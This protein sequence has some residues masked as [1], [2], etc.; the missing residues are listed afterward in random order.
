MAM[1]NRKKIP[2]I[3]GPNQVGHQTKIKT[4]MK[5]NRKKRTLSRDRLSVSAAPNTEMISKLHNIKVV[6]KL[7]RVAAPSKISLGMVRRRI[8]SQIKGT[9]ENLPGLVKLRTRTVE[10]IGLT[11]ITIG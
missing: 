5:N 7:H 4:G 8:A 2:R 11:R 3:K 6:G 10:A 1:G 9:G